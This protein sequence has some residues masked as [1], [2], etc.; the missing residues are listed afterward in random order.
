MTLKELR[1]KSVE[2]LHR[3]IKSRTEELRSL[4]FEAANGSLRLV[5]AFDQAKKEIARIKT[6][7]T[8]RLAEKKNTQ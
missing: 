6:I 1:E 2:E 8:E 3:I 5:H 7:L 4:R